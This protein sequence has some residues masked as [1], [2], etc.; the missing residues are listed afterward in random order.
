VC[1]FRCGAK[2]V[3]VTHDV[4]LLIK[5]LSSAAQVKRTQAASN[6]LTRATH[7]HTHFKCVILSYFLVPLNS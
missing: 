7:T 1:V 4:V 2:A 3:V 6:R 5:Y